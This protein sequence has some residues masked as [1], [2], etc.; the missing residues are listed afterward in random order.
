MELRYYLHCP[1]EPAPNID[2]E[3]LKKYS[4]VRIDYS[5]AKKSEDPSQHDAAE[6]NGDVLQAAS[7]PPHK[8]DT[9]LDDSK[10]TE[11]ITKMRGLQ[12]NDIKI[13]EKENLKADK[14]DTAQGQYFD[15]FCLSLISLN[16]RLA[17][18]FE[19]FSRLSFTDF[20]C[21]LFM[22]RTNIA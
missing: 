1:L 19:H 18:I 13:N 8:S 20:L 3:D 22:F 16:F 17:L 5:K 10:P 12:A 11:Q 6:A 14:V 2:I 9:N 15:H 4:S 21:S 7:Q